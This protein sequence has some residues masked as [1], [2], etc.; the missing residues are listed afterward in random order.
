MEDNQYTAPY[1]RKVIL[2]AKIIIVL[3]GKVVW[4][5]YQDILDWHRDQGYDEKYIRDM[6]LLK[7][8]WHIWIL[9]LKRNMKR[10]LP[11]KTKS[12]AK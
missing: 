1:I 11:L 3:S 10:L 5:S 2:K 12:S 6:L 7:P 4:N 8:R 9:P